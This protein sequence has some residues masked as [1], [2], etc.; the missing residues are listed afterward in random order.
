MASRASVRKATVLASISRRSAASSASSSSGRGLFF[1]GE[2]LAA[3]R[4]RSSPNWSMVS[5]VYSGLRSRTRDERRSD[6][7]GTGGSLVRGFLGAFCGAAGVGSTRPSRTSISWLRRMCSSRCSSYSE[8]SSIAA[9]PARYATVSELDV[10]AAARTAHRTAHPRER[11]WT[12]PLFPRKLG[13]RCN[14]VNTVLRSFGV[15]AA[16][17]S[18]PTRRRRT[19]CTSCSTVWWIRHPSSTGGGSARVARRRR[20]PTSLRRCGGRGACTLRASSRGTASDAWCSWGPRGD[21]RASWV[22]G[23]VFL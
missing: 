16:S 7:G 20:G 19:T 13:S 12:A 10:A 18:G 14:T 9:P 15:C 6:S 17:L 11:T 22:R 4:S 5:L 1:A 2:R 21:S 8:S 3:C 23:C